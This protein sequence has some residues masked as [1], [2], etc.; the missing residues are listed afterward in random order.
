M[1]RRSFLSFIGTAAA[2]GLPQ[3]SQAAAPIP[4]PPPPRKPFPVSEFARESMKISETI[5]VDQWNTFHCKL[6]ERQL[7]DLVA[8]MDGNF[9]AFFRFSTDRNAAAVFADTVTKEQADLVHGLIGNLN[10]A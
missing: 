6:T 4:P 5:T 7:K 2:A 10:R 1:K 9:V 8:W 3:K